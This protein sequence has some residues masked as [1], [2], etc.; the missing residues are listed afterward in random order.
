MLTEN[1]PLLHLKEN[2]REEEKYLM[3][4][5]IIER[6]IEDITIAE[7]TSERELIVLNLWDKL[8]NPYNDTPKEVK[9]ATLLFTQYSII[10]TINGFF[11]KDYYEILYDK[12]N[13]HDLAKIYKY[14][15]DKEINISK[16]EEWLRKDIEER[17]KKLKKKVDEYLC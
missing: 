13:L 3:Q 7:V 10:L 2:I 9:Q 1:S 14:F 4:M 8:Y 11:K 12:F 17:I 5:Y 6:L 15:K 16:I